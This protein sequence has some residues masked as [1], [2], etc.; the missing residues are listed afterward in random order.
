MSEIRFV[1]TTLRDGQL[2]RLRG[3]AGFKGYKLLK[4]QLVGSKGLHY[5]A[6]ADV[7]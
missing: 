2:T 5:R 7:A 1:D 3:F 4:K 6:V